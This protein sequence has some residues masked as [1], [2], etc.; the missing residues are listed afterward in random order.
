MVLR[1]PPG[2][3]KH[4]LAS[5]NIFLGAGNF[6]VL[7]LP[8]RYTVGQT[9]NPAEVNATHPARGASWVIDGRCSHFL[10]DANGPS[11]EFLFVSDRGSSP[12]RWAV[13]A[14]PDRRIGDHEAVLLLDTMTVGFPRRREVGRLRAWWACDRTRRSPRLEIVAPVGVDLVAIGFALEHSECH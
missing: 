9:I 13:G 12:P 11:L 8:E 3:H 1:E 14:N 5:A 10:R 7:A 6:L 4:V 2:V